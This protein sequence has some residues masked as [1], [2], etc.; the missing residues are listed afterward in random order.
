MRLFS[1]VCKV[2]RNE[3]IRGQYN[4][5]IVAPPKYITSYKCMV[6]RKNGTTT[7][8]QSNPQ[9]YVSSYMR[10]YVATNAN[11]LP[12]DIVEHRGVKYKAGLPYVLRTHI[13][14]DLTFMEEL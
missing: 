11:I 4:N 1:D 12:G 14:V 2:Y 6:S 13:E 3:V 8:T 7:V 10:L 5:P 9:A